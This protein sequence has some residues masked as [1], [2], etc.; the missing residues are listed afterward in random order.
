MNRTAYFLCFLGVALLASVQQLALAQTDDWIGSGGAT[1]STGGAGFVSSPSGAATDF[2]TGDKVQF[3]NIYNDLSPSQTPSSYTVQINGTVN[4]SQV[5]VN[6]DTAANPSDTYMFTGSGT[7]G[8]ASS[9]TS[10]TVAA[11]TLNIANISGNTYSNG[12]TVSGGTLLANNAGGSATGSGSVTV[13]ATAT[14]GG[15]G[16][17]GGPVTIDSGG[18]LAPSATLSPTAA[19][20]L[21]INNSLTLNDG[22]SLNYNLNTPNV[23]GTG[24]GNDLTT[25][26][27]GG[28]LNINPDLNVNVTAGTNFGDGSYELVHYASGN[29]T[30]LSNSF[31]G[32]NVNFAP[33]TLAPNTFETL[34]YSF[35]NDTANDDIDLNVTSMSSSSTAPVLS[36]G[37]TTTTVQQV[38]SPI[39]IKITTTV[40]SPNGKSS[41][42]GGSGGGSKA[43]PTGGAMVARGMP[44]GPG[45][46]NMMSQGAKP[47]MFM[48]SVKAPTLTMLPPNTPMFVAKGFPYNTLNNLSPAAVG[49]A[50]PIVVKDGNGTVVGAY[51]PAGTKPPQAVPNDYLPGY[52]LAPNFSISDPPAVAQ[53]TYYGLD[54]SAGPYTDIYLADIIGGNPVLPETLD[55]TDVDGVLE[56]SDAVDEYQGSF[57][58]LIQSDF[59]ATDPSQLS[60]AQWDDLEGSYGYD[61]VGLVAWAVDDV[62]SGVYTVVGLGSPVPLPTSLAGG[63]LMMAIA[64]WI[65]MRWNRKSE[66]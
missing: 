56:G 28:T 43:P 50:T 51:Y 24:G 8:D 40:S 47:K 5:Y 20:N 60:N 55:T 18:F 62:P 36:V 46:G 38:G 54:Y 16:F 37:Q 7:I 3:E 15:G 33:S 53:P 4:P 2:S 39:S 26:T 21:T 29:I 52:Y 59:G 48:I 42:A 25:V 22:A 34:S 44:Q 63:A 27:N 9:P 66:A 1:W 13:N 45:G 11:G 31:S 64:A 12:T 17:I 58:S 19:T 6:T 30:N 61:P 49:P 32:W 14:I 23:H 65:W 41:P 35:Q 57:L 10:L